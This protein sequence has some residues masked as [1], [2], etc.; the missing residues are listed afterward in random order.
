[1]EMCFLP[2]PLG[3]HQGKG[4]F[5]RVERS[6]RWEGS[7]GTRELLIP[8]LLLP[9]CL[10]GRNIHQQGQ[11]VLPALG[12]GKD[13]RAFPFPQP[14]KLT[15]ACAELMKF[16]LL[17]P[18]QEGFFFSQLGIQLA[19]VFLQKVQE[20]AG[21]GGVQPF[22]A[23]PR[24]WGKSHSSFFLAAEC[25]FLCILQLAGTSSPRFLFTCL[26]ISLV[27]GLLN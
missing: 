19:A 6:W 27:S 8:E 11:G 21:I 16:L 20:L 22:S 24:C 26:V 25:L 15:S 12:R 23:P 7:P 10:V 3:I 13:H 9:G 5:L 14:P 2:V 17:S 18:L 1:M 4:W